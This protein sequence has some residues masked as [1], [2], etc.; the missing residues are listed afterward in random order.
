VVLNIHIF[1]NGAPIS[2]PKAAV[3]SDGVYFTIICPNCGERQQRRPDP[4][5]LWWANSR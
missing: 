3:N 2:W 4:L 5:P 1:S